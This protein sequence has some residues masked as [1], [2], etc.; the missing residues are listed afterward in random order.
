[1]LLRIPDG[2]NNVMTCWK[3]ERA[4]G[5]DFVPTGGG[6]PVLQRPYDRRAFP[7]SGVTSNSEENVTGLRRGVEQGLRIATYAHTVVGQCD[8]ARLI[9]FLISHAN[10]KCVCKCT[11]MKMCAFT[12]F[13]LCIFY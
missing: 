7:P 4:P 11:S 9:G 10:A 5:D 3:M 8:S 6:V 2:P 13:R 12:N 1:M